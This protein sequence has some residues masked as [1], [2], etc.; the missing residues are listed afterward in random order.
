MTSEIE[1]AGPDDVDARFAL[2][3]QRTRER[4]GISQADL[5]KRL[6]DSGWTNVHQTTISRIEK[7]ERPARLGEARAI[8]R[9]LNV[10][11]NQLMLAPG[12]SKLAARISWQRGRVR[13]ARQTISEAAILFF[14]ERFILQEVVNEILEM[15]VV[16]TPVPDDPMSFSSLASTGTV[17]DELA[18]AIEQ[19]ESDPVSSINYGKLMSRSKRNPL[20]PKQN[21]NTNDSE[22]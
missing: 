13:D 22:T 11:L 9:A 18:L 8:A 16:P 7:G 15:G 20:V 1:L 12:S 21:D 10:E 4:Y 17:E 5:I 14:D 19:L 3:M 2:N 6:K